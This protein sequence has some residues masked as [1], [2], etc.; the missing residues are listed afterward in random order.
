MKQ[1]WISYFKRKNSPFYSRTADLLSVLYYSRKE[2]PCDIIMTE[3]QPPAPSGDG[4]SIFQNLYFANF[5]LIRA[6]SPNHARSFGASI[7]NI[8]TQHKRYMYS[9]V[10]NSKFVANAELSNTLVYYFFLSDSSVRWFFCGK[11]IPSKTTYLTV[12]HPILRI[13]QERMPRKLRITEYAQD[14]STY[15]TPNYMAH[16][17]PRFEVEQYK[18]WWNSVKELLY[19]SFQGT[20]ANYDGF[21]SFDYSNLSR[22]R[23]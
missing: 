6:I 22:I 4:A 13:M 12:G 21:C 19:R 7:I 10:I 23:Q 3:R 9:S 18:K 5:W 11:S 14:C 16:L 17:W 15:D 2:H 8:L 1:C 20:E